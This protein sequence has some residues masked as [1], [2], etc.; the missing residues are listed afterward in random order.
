MISSAHLSL[1]GSNAPPDLAF[2]ERQSQ[3]IPDSR[4]SPHDLRFVIT[5]RRF[6][7]GDRFDPADRRGSFLGDDAILVARPDKLERAQQHPLAHNSRYRGS[8]RSDDSRLRLYPILISRVEAAS[9][10]SRRRNRRFHSHSPCA[11]SIARRLSKR[12]P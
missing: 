5:S 6:H 8:L 4:R 1:F 2:T 7:Y 3:P 9:S 10:H 11:E 12:A